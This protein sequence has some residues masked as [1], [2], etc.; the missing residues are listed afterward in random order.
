LQ[1]R[2]ESTNETIKQAVM[3]ALGI[4]FISAHKIAAEIWDGR[5]QFST[6]GVYRTSASGSWSVLPRNE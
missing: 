2:N 5:W 3:A 1:Q 6:S 4:A